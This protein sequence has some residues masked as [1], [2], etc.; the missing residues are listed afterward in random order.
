MTEYTYSPSGTPDM[1]YIHTAVAAS[2]MSDKDIDHCHYTSGGSLYVYF[3]N[4]LEAGDK[5][6]LDGIVSDSES[7]TYTRKTIKQLLDDIDA[8]CPAEQQAELAT[9]TT[10]SHIPLLH[11]YIASNS[12]IK[13][14]SYLDDLETAEEITAA[15]NTHLQAQLPDEIIT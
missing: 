8:N 13:I 12:L 10:S 6:I 3:T 11:L 9:F 5:T 4:A 14:A 2:A 1:D 15:L 7:V